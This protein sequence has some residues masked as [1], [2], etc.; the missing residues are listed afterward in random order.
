MLAEAPR[1]S[2]PNGPA[3][4]SYSPVDPSQGEKVSSAHAPF[5][6]GLSRWRPIAR[7]GAGPRYSVPGDMPGTSHGT[8]LFTFQIK[9]SHRDRIPTGPG[10]GEQINFLDPLH[11]VHV[12][13]DNELLTP[14]FTQRAGLWKGGRDAGLGR[15]RAGLRIKICLVC[16]GEGQPFFQR[17]SYPVRAHHPPLAN[18]ETRQ[19]SFPRQF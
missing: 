12:Y 10:S 1:P 8:I 2:R 6:A 11:T 9:S 7:L 18:P 17:L 19:L 3:Q 4:K 5:A 15:S 13:F 16:N 14:L